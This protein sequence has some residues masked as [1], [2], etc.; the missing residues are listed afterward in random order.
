MM[1]V[2]RLTRRPAL[3]AIVLL[4]APD[5]ERARLKPMQEGL[6]VA[7]LAQLSM[8]LREDPG[9][10]LSS[11]ARLCSGVGAVALRGGTLSDRI[12]AVRSLLR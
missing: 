11:L 9:V 8:N 7:K 6:A 12:G 3:A 4:A 1:R 2:A 10:S 5:G